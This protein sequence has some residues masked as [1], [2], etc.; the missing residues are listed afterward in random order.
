MEITYRDARLMIARLTRLCER[1]ELSAVCDFCGSPDRKWIFVMPPG[2][3]PELDRE[4]REASGRLDDG[5]WNACEQCAA[6]VEQKNIPALVN[7]VL[8]ALR[9]SGHPRTRSRSDRA[10]LAER[11]A[12]QYAVLLDRPAEKHSAPRQIP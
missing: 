7:V 6:Y 4:R 11:Y 2:V 3:L 5:L 8:G 12:E 1:H 10:E 9:A